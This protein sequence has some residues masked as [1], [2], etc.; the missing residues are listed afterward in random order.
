M[1]FN[2]ILTLLKGSI[3]ISREVLSLKMSFIKEISCIK[4]NFISKEKI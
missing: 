4:K 3:K 2:F 1:L